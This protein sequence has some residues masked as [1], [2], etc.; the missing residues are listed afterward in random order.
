MSTGAPPALGQQLVDAYLWIKVPGESDGSCNRGIA[1][2]TTDP[3]WSAI[4]GHPF[5][6]PAAGAWFPEQALQLAQL[7]NPS[8]F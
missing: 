6:D 2:A 5:V 7:A 8:L 1:G 3:E 4:V